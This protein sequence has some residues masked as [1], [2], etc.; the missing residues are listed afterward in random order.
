ML[1]VR[2]LIHVCF[3]FLEMVP[4]GVCKLG[5]NRTIYEYSRRPR[6]SL[7]DAGFVPVECKAGDLVTF[8]GT[9]DHLSL[10]N[11]STSTRHTFQLHL[12]EGPDAGVT[13]SPQNWLQYPPDIRFLSF[14]TKQCEQH[15]Y[16]TEIVSREGR[17][18]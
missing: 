17:T 1:E 14:T 5:S 7:L 4:Y 13:W 16:Q 10:P 3:L 9:L 11:Y 15:T 8:C 2:K 12:I 18:K 6:K